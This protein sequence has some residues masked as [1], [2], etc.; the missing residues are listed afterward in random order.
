M[1]LQNGI[2]TNV[3]EPLQE[4]DDEEEESFAEKINSR[5]P[6]ER[7]LLLKLFKI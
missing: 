4:G 2:S 3:L 6:S 5:S 1:I 7:V